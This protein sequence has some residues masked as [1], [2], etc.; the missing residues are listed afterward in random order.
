MREA[1]RQELSPGDPGLVGQVGAFPERNAVALTHNELVCLQVGNLP[2]TVIPVYMA[3]VGCP[4][5][6][7]RNTCYSVAPFQKQPITRYPTSALV[8]DPRARQNGR[9]EGR[10]DLSSDS[11]QPW[12]LVLT[13]TRTD[14]RCLSGLSPMQHPCLP[15]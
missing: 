15:R 1:S 4:I 13:G 14:S 5:S 6:A 3:V 9:A 11:L 7:L 8:S 12:V 2:V 10:C